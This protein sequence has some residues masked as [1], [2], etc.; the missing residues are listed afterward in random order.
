MKE[1]LTIEA[2]RAVVQAETAYLSLNN[3]GCLF[4]PVVEAHLH[5]PAPSL[6]L[7]SHRHIWV[8]TTH[9]PLSMLLSLSPTITWEAALFVLIFKCLKC[10]IALQNSLRWLQLRHLTSYPD[11]YSTLRLSCIYYI[12]KISKT[13]TA[14]CNYTALL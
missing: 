7:H 2:H 9:L 3:E 4:Q 14:K 13:N 6:L 11:T 12:E 10:D 8:K 1:H 5:S